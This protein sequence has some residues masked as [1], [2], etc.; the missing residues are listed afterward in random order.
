MIVGYEWRSTMGLKWNAHKQ[1]EVEAMVSDWD[2]AGESTGTGRQIV[3]VFHVTHPD[4]V[5]RPEGIRS[6]QNVLGISETKLMTVAKKEKAAQQYKQQQRESEA[7]MWDRVAHPTAIAA[8]QD[9]RKTNWSGMRSD[10]ENNAI[11]YDTNLWSKGGKFVRRASRAAEDMKDFGWE[12]VEPDPAKQHLVAASNQ[13]LLSAVRAERLAR[14]VEAVRAASAENDSKTVAKVIL[15]DEAGR[16]L[17][18]TDSYSGYDDL[19]GG[20]VQRGEDPVAGLVREVYEETGIRLVASDVTLY[21]TQDIPKPHGGRML[22]YKARVDAAKVKIS[23]EHSGSAWVKRDQLGQRNLG[24]YAKDV[25]AALKPDSSDFHTAARDKARSE[26]KRAALQA[27]GLAAHA[28]ADG[29][30]AHPDGKAKVVGGM[31]AFMALGAAAAYLASRQE[32]IEG[33]ISPGVRLGPDEDEADA[34]AK[35]RE[36]L[37]TGAVEDAVA[38]LEAEKAAVEQ[39][40][41]ARGTVI[42]S[43]LSKRLAKK[44][45]ELEGARWERIADA[46]ATATYGAAALRVLDL[47]GFAT[48][49][50]SQLDRPTKRHT[51]KLNQDQGEQPLGF[52]FQ[53]GQSHPGD[54]ARGPE[55]NINC[56]CQL[57]GVR[58][59]AEKVGAS[60]PFEENK[61]PRT[62]GGRFSDKFLYHSEIGSW[63]G[64]VKVG[65]K[66]LSVKDLHLINKEGW[67]RYQ[68]PPS[69]AME[70]AMKNPPES[71]A[72]LFSNLKLKPNPS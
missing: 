34:H 32:L 15:Q 4:G 43:E 51:H 14:R 12:Q 53:N 52:V 36:P 19:P 27:L 20:H 61:H 62:S 46:E 65:G 13:T 1:E 31:L 22:L 25:E 56:L 45:R 29:Q 55:E 3:H 24:R 60:E 37:I 50:W 26:H 10:E 41:V 64:T 54:P 44:A 33:E 69:K 48:V 57:V 11:F 68:G 16:V 21:R 67:I 28:V 17:V 7:K 70:E 35:T 71:A 49:R 9:Y 2:H 6:A 38:E 23:E 40:Q 58:R 5:T 66:W 47:A 8:A 63:R 72:A 18:L 59:K 42:E 30:T 39:E